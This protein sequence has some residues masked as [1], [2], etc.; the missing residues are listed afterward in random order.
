AMA[1]S[2][3]RSSWLI[4]ARNSAL[5]RFAAA[6]TLCAIRSSRVTRSRSDIDAPRMRNV[7]AVTAM[8]ACSANRLVWRVDCTN[9]P[10]PITVPHTAMTETMKEVV[11]EPHCPNRIAAQMRNGNSSEARL[12]GPS[13]LDGGCRKT[14]IL[15]TINATLIAIASTNR[16]PDGTRGGDAETR[17][18]GETND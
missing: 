15:A 4:T 5:A 8:N 6:A 18:G 14:T 9:G 2:G 11:T 10:R 13:T 3:V 16:L 7:A 12:I 17:I 1:L